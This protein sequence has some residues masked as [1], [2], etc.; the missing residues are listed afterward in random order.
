M[1]A[2]TLVWLTVIATGSQMLACLFMDFLHRRREHWSRR[3]AIRFEMSQE[4]QRLQRQRSTR[5]ADI[6]AEATKR[7]LKDW[8]E[9]QT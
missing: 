4:V 3:Q 2:E 9:S 8:L 6:V 1:S 7:T 5:E